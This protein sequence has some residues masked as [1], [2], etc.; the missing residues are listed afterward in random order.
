MDYFFKQ[1]EGI[2]G[3][4]PLETL[5]QFAA[6]GMLSS[7]HSIS[8]DRM[9]WV[10]ANSL[11]GIPKPGP[12]TLPAPA[13]TPAPGHQGAENQFAYGRGFGIFMIVLAVVGFLSG[14]PRFGMI[15]VLYL[16]GHGIYIMVKGKKK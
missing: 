6:D 12:T 14:H 9:N 3:P 8:T 4:Y 7:D 15:F 2:H 16:I 10:P 11:S 1:G 13:A 5:R